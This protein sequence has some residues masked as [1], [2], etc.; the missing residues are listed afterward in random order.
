LPTSIEQAGIDYDDPRAAAKDVA[1]FSRLSR[2]G[3]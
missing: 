3:A 2:L 1:D